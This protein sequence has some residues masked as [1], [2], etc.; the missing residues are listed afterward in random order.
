MGHVVNPISHRVSSTL[1]DSVVLHTRYNAHYAFIYNKLSFVSSYV[2]CMLNSFHLRQIV[3]LDRVKIF[4][5]KGH[6]NLVVS[7]YSSQVTELCLFSQQCMYL[8]ATPLL[9]R[10][11]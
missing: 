6:L 9:R 5:R 8:E 3:L 10:H 4:Q 11:E 2:S 1:V 7:L